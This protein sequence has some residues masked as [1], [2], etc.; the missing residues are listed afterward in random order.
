MGVPVVAQWLRIRLGSMRF[1]VRSL[2]LLSGLGSGVAVSCGVGCRCGSD[3]KLLWL[4]RRLTA[5]APIQPLAW[6]PPYATGA[7]LEMA[8]RQK[9]NNNNKIKEIPCT[10]P[11]W[12]CCILELTSLE[13]A[14][15]RVKSP[16][17]LV[18]NCSLC[19]LRPSHAALLSL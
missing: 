6:E 3:P 12:T 8:K 1:Q 13:S 18:S 10:L 9:K 7:A 4:W 2:A 5:T 16:N 17:F 19:S 11:A 15:P 14:R